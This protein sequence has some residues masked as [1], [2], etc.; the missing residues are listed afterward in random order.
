MNRIQSNFGNTQLLMSARMRSYPM[1]SK[2]VKRI[3]GYTQLGN[4][5]RAG[6]FKKIINQL[7]LKNY[8]KVLDLGCGQGEYSFMMAKSFPKLSITALDIESE[9][10]QK[11]KE[12]ASNQ[13]LHNLKT[14]L[15]P[16]DSFPVKD[17][18][19]DFIYSIDVFEHLSEDK[20]PFEAA[21]QRLK[22][23]GVLVIK[24][25]SKK[26]STLLPARLFEE[27][28]EWL[29]D[30]HIG[31]IYE[32]EDLKNRMQSAGFEIVDAFYADGPLAR[33]GWEISYLA[34][35]ISL[36]LHLLLL[37]FTKILV[38]IDQLNPKRKKGNTIQV[39]GKKIKSYAKDQ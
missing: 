13:E 23:E 29:E 14:H 10:I 7:P 3:F 39:I 38:R 17:G 27:H 37:P 8:S 21:H 5:A 20:M 2:L 18:N 4:Y 12:L 32:L 19:F 36:I 11:I 16:I 1:L 22:Q 6:I 24:M 25:P 35:K 34:K 9:R 26:Q 15:G 30:E 28:A 31:Q 33:L